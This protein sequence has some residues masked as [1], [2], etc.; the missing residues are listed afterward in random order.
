M[1]G[2]VASEGVSECY[3]LVWCSKCP[4]WKSSERQNST[5]LTPLKHQNT[6]TSLYKLSKNHWVIALFKK[7]GSVRKR[8][9]STVSLDHPVVLFQRRSLSFITIT[10]L[11]HLGSVKVILLPL[12]TDQSARRAVTR[13][14]IVCLQ[15]RES[16]SFSGRRG[17]H[18]NGRDMM[19]CKG[20]GCIWLTCTI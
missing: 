8:L 4:Y 1:Y 18:R 11:R 7:I 12:L 9:Q 20:N 17:G 14:S 6:K 2:F 3:G 13:E 10:A 19:E 15:R 16:E 5:H